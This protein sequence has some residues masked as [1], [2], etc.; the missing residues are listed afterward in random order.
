MEKNPFLKEWRSI[1][2]T[3]DQSKVIQ[4]CKNTDEDDVKQLFLNNNCSFLATRII[5]NRGISM[6]FVTTL[7]D[8]SML[9][10]MS[11]ANNTAVRANVKSRNKYL[12]FVSAQTCID[13]INS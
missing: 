1:P 7:K 13:I 11:I 5:P 4:S 10:E 3:D 9:I 2:D 12:S 6:Y 8:V